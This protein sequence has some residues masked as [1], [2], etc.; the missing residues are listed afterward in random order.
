MIPIIKNL[1]SEI[2][3][4]IDKIRQIKKWPSKSQW[5]RLYQILTQKEKKTALLFLAIIFISGILMLANFYFSKTKIAGGYGG[6]YTEGIIGQPRFI[7]PVLSQTNDTDRDLVELIFS[8]LMRYNKEG[9]V[10]P[11]LAEKYEISGD[12]KTY[13]FF[14][15]KAFWHDGKP[16]NADDVLFTIKIIQDPDYKS[17]L[18]LNWQGVGVEK[19]DDSTVKFTLNNSYAPFLENTTLKIIPKHLWQDVSP[20][21]FSLAEYNL[22]P[23]G[24]G[25]YKFK[26]YEKDFSGSIKSLY[27]RSYENYHIKEPYIE[28]II[29]RFFPDEKS[30]A[31]S[32]YKSKIDGINFI[33]P[34]NLSLIKNIPGL[35]IYS[36]HLP[37]Y[38]AVF[39]NQ[40]QSKALSD[41]TVRLALAYATDKKEIIEEVLGDKAMQVESPIPPGTL[42]YTPETKIYDFALEHANNILEAAGWKM[43]EDNV[44]KKGEDRLEI[45]LTTTDWPQLKQTAEILS[46]QW[47]K[48]GAKI[49]LN[50]LSSTDVQQEYI[51]PRKYQALLFGEILGHDPDPF[52]FWHSSQKSDPGLNLALYGNKATDKLLEEAR[53]ILDAQQRISKYKEFSKLVAD[54]APAVFLFSPDYLYPMNKKIK[55]IE[56]KNVVTPSQRFAEIENWFIKTKRIKKY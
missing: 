45:T 41:K 38:F 54:D 50:I 29:F 27:L 22:K 31:A 1:F 40:S 14:L 53:Q 47:E 36:L 46:K 51:R 30:A 18:R 16:I 52:S 42:G 35:N 33:S 15:K 2:K 43:V 9:E 10:I 8:G 6:T 5:L 25:P 48:I 32:L 17:P 39:F 56:V 20:S 3:K 24:S 49:N 28:N 23:I 26:K 37:Q 12:G 55:G 13:T 19:V 11:D 4:R 34:D 7:N 44:R 21:N